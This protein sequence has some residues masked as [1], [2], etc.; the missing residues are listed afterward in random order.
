MSDIG[1]ACKYHVCVCYEDAGARMLALVLVSYSVLGRGRGV[2][3]IGQSIGSRGNSCTTC[4]CC[5][6]WPASR[7]G[8]WVSW[9]LF[10]LD[11]HVPLQSACGL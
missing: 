2:S 3:S 9:G 8:A 10:V 5:G 4:F 11:L 6:V 7:C 1:L